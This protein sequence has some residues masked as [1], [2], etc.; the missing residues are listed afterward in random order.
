MRSLYLFFRCQKSFKGVNFRLAQSGREEQKGRAII[1]PA[2]MAEIV[3]GYI[4][5]IYMDLDVATP[6]VPRIGVA[7]KNTLR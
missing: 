5:F 7:S 4:L 1:N 6:K 3:K 2:G